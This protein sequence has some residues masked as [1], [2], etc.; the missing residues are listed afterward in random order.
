M[1]YPSVVI[2]FCSLNKQFSTTSRGQCCSVCCPLQCLIFGKQ[3]IP[4]MQQKF[5]AA[6]GCEMSH[7]AAWVR[8]TEKST[9]F[10]TEKQK[11]LV[12]FGIFREIVRTSEHRPQ[13]TSCS[14]RAGTVTLP[15]YTTTNYSVTILFV[16]CSGYPALEL[17]HDL[18]KSGSDQSDCRTVS[19]LSLRQFSTLQPLPLKGCSGQ[20]Q[21]IQGIQT[22]ANQAKLV[23]L[24]KD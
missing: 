11:G 20:C 2:H 8:D 12:F 16:D 7:E 15:V 10:G 18:L 22:S 21:S 23:L 14:R 1:K 5:D 6:N 4:T 19:L 3:Y 24:G 9:S 13:S 17:Q